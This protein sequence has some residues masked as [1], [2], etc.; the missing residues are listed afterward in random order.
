MIT[1]GQIANINKLAKYNNYDILKRKLVEETAELIVALSQIEDEKV[2]YK[3]IISECIDI[4]VVGQQ[5]LTM[6]GY[7]TDELSGD[8]CFVHLNNENKRAALIDRINN[9]IKNDFT[10]HHNILYLCYEAKGTIEYLIK[11]D[12]SLED[13][14]DEELDFKINRQLKRMSY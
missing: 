10:L 5:L 4:I 14:F 11:K 8:I 6:K 3:D 12:A 7:A 13:F 9:I 1:I 2:T